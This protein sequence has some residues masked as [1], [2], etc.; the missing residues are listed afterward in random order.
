VMSSDLITP[1]SFSFETRAE[2]SRLSG[3]VLHV[4]K[5][6]GQS[7]LRRVWWTATQ[8]STFASFFHVAWHNELPI[9]VELIQKIVNR[10]L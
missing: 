6:P 4:A 5:I 9:I 3:V 7:P 1:V 10:D 8:L 2:L